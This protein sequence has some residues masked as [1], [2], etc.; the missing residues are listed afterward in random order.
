M[1]VHRSRNEDD[2]VCSREAHGGA[3]Q[4]L[5][6]VKRFCSEWVND[7]EFQITAFIKELVDAGFLEG[8]AYTDYLESKNG[9]GGADS[10]VNYLKSR[11]AIA[12]THLEAHPDQDDHDV[13]YAL[14]A[15]EIDDPSWKDRIYDPE[16]VADQK[17]VI[18]ELYAEIAALER[19]V[20]DCSCER[21]KSC[22][23]SAT[24]KCRICD[25]TDYYV[26]KAAD[27]SSTEGK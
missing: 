10:R 6:T 13:R 11:I 19:R 15:L 3:K 26:E 20:A 1:G 23:R 5:P 9:S 4:L 25:G 8:R 2:L 22:A 21:W 24:G 17:R 7:R 16:V 27:K 14:E 12:R 18:D